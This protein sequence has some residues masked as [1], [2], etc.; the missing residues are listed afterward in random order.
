MCQ[1]IDFVELIWFRSITCG[2]KGDNCV[3]GRDVWHVWHV[4]HMWHAQSGSIQ[5]VR[6]QPPQPRAEQTYPPFVSEYLQSTLQAPRRRNRPAIPHRM[7]LPSANQTVPS[8][9]APHPRSPK[10]G[11]FEPIIEPTKADTPMRIRCE[12]VRSN[13]FCRPCASRMAT[14]IE[15]NKTHA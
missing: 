5:L 8:K 14:A 11:I 4:W 13:R 12:R 9:K 15:K 2:A 1:D 10:N 7:V 6:W 3:W